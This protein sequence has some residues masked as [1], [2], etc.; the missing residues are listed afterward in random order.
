MEEVVEVVGGFVSIPSTVNARR[1]RSHF[2]ISSGKSFDLG[3][4]RSPPS[5]AEAE[6]AY[7]E[8]QSETTMDLSNAVLPHFFH[9]L[10][11]FDVDAD[12]DDEGV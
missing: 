10:S 9:R 1:M 7:P 2:A 4:N 8:A 3:Q 11:S 5:F 12:E 6:L